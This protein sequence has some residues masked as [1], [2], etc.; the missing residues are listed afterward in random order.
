MPLRYLPTCLS[1]QLIKCICRYILWGYEGWR[2]PLHLTSLFVDVLYKV[3]LLEKLK[4]LWLLVTPSLIQDIYFDIRTSTVDCLR[5]AWTTPLKLAKLLRRMNLPYMLHTYACI[6]E[7]DN[8]LQRT[9]VQF[10][11]CRRIHCI[12]N[13]VGEVK[14]PI[15]SLKFIINIDISI[16]ITVLLWWTLVNINKLQP[17]IYQRVC[18]VGEY[19]S[20]QSEDWTVESLTDAGRI[21][22]TIIQLVAG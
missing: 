6:Q 3:Y 12:C 17:F 13:S 16:P 15:F 20:Y 2:R 22:T 1:Y 14:Y 9:K 11:M 8:F 5:T 7:A 18:L 19:E 10:P 4:Y 21:P